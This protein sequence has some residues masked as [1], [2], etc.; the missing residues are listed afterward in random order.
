MSM[1]PAG[2]IL[3]VEDQDAVRKMV[4]AAL[5]A[6]GYKNV[7]EADGPDRALEIAEQNGTPIQLLLTDINLGSDIDGIQLAKK[8]TALSS[9]TKVLLMSG[10]AN[11]PL[12]L[13]TGWH[14]IPKP[15][16]P[17]ELVAAVRTSLETPSVEFRQATA[18]LTVFTLDLKKKII[19]AGTT[20]ED[21]RIGPGHEGLLSGNSNVASFHHG[22]EVLFNL[23]PE[24]VTRTRIVAARNHLHAA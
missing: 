3:L 11:Q 9:G 23:A 17:S 7:A 20:L 19:P 2:T 14:F 8:I 18:D 1:T 22:G 5:S 4:Q 15:F 12:V 24:I 16:T 13:E 6:F 21:F 10:H